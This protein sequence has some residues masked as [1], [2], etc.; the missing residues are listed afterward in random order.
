MPI[1]LVTGPANAGKAHVLLEAVRAHVA[2]G[3]CPLLIVPTEADQARYRRE[4]A[5]GGAALGVRVERFEGLLSAVVARAGLTEALLGALARERVLARL[6][7]ARPG[8]AG[9][10]VRFVGELETQRVT[11]GRL[12]G[13]LGVW[14]ASPAQLGAATTT[15]ERVCAVFEAYHQALAKIGRADRELRITRALDALRREPALW[16]GTPVALYGFDDLTELQLDAIETLGGVVDV[17]VTVSLAYEPGRVVFAGRAGAYQRLSPLADI[18]S[19]LEPR[20]DYYALGSRQALHHLERSLLTDDP[21]RVG[22]GEAVRLLEGGSPRSELELVAGEVRGLLDAGVRAEEVAIVHRSPET[23]AGL[24]GEVLTGFGVPYALRERVRFADTAVGRGLLGLMRCA[25]GDGALGDLLAWLRAPGVL[26]RPELADRLEARALRQ[27]AT[28]AAHARALWEAEHW[29]LERIDR[30][31]EQ[32]LPALADALAAELY[33]LFCAPR[34]ARAALLGEG[35]LDEGRALV[36]GRRALEELRDLS[37]AAPEL[38]PAPFELIEVL[39]RLELVGGMPPGS[40]MVVV[41]DPLSLRARRVRM[42]FACGLQEGVFPAPS[43]PHPLLGEDERRALAQASGLALRGEPDALASERYL[44]YALASRPEERL[45]L[46]WHT[47]SEDG[48]PLARSLFVDDVCDLFAPTLRRHTARRFAGAADWPGPGRPAGTMV[49]REAAIAASTATRSRPI[50]PL[51]DERVLGNLRERTLWS[52]SSLETW[53][54]CPVKWFVERLLRAQEIDPTP[55]P[56]ARGGLA[57]AALKDTFE[58]LRE[59][60]GSARLTPTS[61]GLAKRVLGEALARHEPHHPL[62][63][64][65]ERLPGARR[66]LQADLERYLQCASEQTSPLEPTHLE[67]EFGFAGHSELG[68]GVPPSLPAMEL[69]GGVLLR[70]RIDRVDVGVGGEAVI[71]DYKGRSAPPGARWASDGAFQIALYMRAVEQLLGY[72]PV[73]GFYQPLAGRDIRARGVL[74]G[75]SDVELECV[76]TDLREHRELGELL[77]QCGTAALQAA[78]EAK[79][80]ALEPRPESCA[81][82]GGCAYPTICRCER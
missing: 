31:R 53:A 9:T 44:L 35:E 67:L 24:L 29:P 72:R 14:S 52:A 16:G 60:T 58:Q 48:T 57:H 77:E 30:I 23:I 2:H 80:G 32:A 10:L 22:P 73:G 59:R 6:A 46:S 25:L 43:V 81:F 82:Q 36:N 8:T 27:G 45:T 47:A 75:D 12:R 13:A 11:P 19:A 62:S 5:E 15:L 18:H 54:G 34:R 40:G 41:A 20:A 76:R 61:V 69:G 33:R 3:D 64:A 70:G 7:Q 68:D 55:E 4:L 71:Y 63:V 42:V 21:V 79:S 56:I 65:P 38:A 39:E 37:R 49:G 26:D 1:T 50:A 28:S 78:T 51:A 66:R 74:D 17:R